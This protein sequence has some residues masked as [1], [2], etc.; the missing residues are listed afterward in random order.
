MKAFRVA[1]VVLVLLFSVIIGWI[2]YWNENDIMPVYGDSDGEKNG[3]VYV[4]AE[5]WV[6]GYSTI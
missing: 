5:E 6:D 2:S 3:F 4:K 1:T